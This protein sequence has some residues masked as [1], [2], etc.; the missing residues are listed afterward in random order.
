MND[1]LAYL[2]VAAGLV[3]LAFR[4]GGRSGGV[5]RATVTNT[6][7]PQKVHKPERL[8]YGGSIGRVL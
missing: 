2:L 3:A 5:E 6:D 4:L 7:A 1:A 8:I